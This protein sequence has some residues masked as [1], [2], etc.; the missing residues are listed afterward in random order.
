MYIIDIKL[1]TLDAGDFSSQTAIDTFRISW[2]TSRNAFESFL[3]TD[4]MANSIKMVVPSKI[5]LS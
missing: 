3:D 4:I 5:D 2:I 1:L